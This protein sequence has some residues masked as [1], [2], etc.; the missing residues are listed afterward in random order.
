[1]NDHF[2]KN[3]NIEK[4]KCFSNFSVA[5]FSH[6]N[7]IGGKNNIGKTALLES[8]YLMVHA[9]SIDLFSS[10]IYVIAARRKYPNENK[11]DTAKYFDEHKKIKIKTNHDSVLFEHIDKELKRSFQ[12]E[13]N[14]DSK[15]ISRVDF[16]KNINISG[17]PDNKL[18]I[19]PL[20][21]GNSSG[22]IG[23]FGKIQEEDREGEVNEYIKEFDSS[24]DV[25][26]I[27]GKTAKVKKNGKYYSL[28]HFGDGLKAY[29]AIILAIYSCKNGILLIDEIE[30]GIHYTQLDRLWQIILTISKNANCQIFVTTHSKECI[31]AFNRVQL[32]N[33][34]SSS[35]YF[36]LYRN[37]KTNKITAA[38]RTDEQLEYALTHQGKI[39][40][41]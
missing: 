6:I 30:N 17:S 19:T 12:F 5:D 1:M 8:L 29:I 38:R 23:L 27:I 10:A 15:N 31:Q 39:R 16:F 11:N 2:I 4:F 24:L 22:L 34:S 37:F 25:F 28:S 14:K 26:K 18:L 20:R 33:E 9:T 7:L 36:E 21:L 40:G 32:E 3:I 13:I 35:A 41:E